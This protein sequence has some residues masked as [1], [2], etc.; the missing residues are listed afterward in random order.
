M[1]IEI[2]VTLPKVYSEWHSRPD[3]D[4]A[5]HLAEIFN[6]AR[7]NG[8]ELEVHIPKAVLN[9]GEDTPLTR[10]DFMTYSTGTDDDSFLFDIPSD[11]SKSNVFS[12]HRYTINVKEGVAGFGIE[13]K[14][15]E[16]FSVFLTTKDIS[17]IRPK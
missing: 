10:Q 6:Y 11:V 3:S 5:K 17:S 2:G 7:E 12:R 16:D 4:H 8:I 1:G 14:N 9:R 13:I 15:D